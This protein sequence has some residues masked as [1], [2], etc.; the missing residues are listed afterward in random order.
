M[1]HTAPATAPADA[2]EQD[3]L[4]IGS[5]ALAVRVDPL[6]ARIGS[7]VDRR[8][9]TEFLLVT[10]WA[11][12][13]WDPVPLSQGSSVEWHR[14]YPGGW[15]TLVP[16]SG[17]ERTVGGMEHPFHG[18]AS[19]RT[20]RLVDADPSSCTHEVVLRTVPLR[21]R[22]SVRIDGGTVRVTQTVTNL[23]PEAVSFTWTEHPALGPAVVGPR[24][25]VT[26]CGED[27]GVQFP[28]D[29]GG[30]G[31]FRSI[32]VAGAGDA[33]VTDPDTGAFARLT[34]DVALLPHLHVWQEHHATDGFPW[35]RTVNTIALEPA[36]R[37]YW[38]E[39]DRLGPVV[40]DGG[41]RVTGE[42]A[43]EVGFVTAV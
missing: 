1:T 27:V 25:R 18:E 22:R 39:D 29:E 38:P 12:E 43:L 15:H 10:P 21:V 8:T 9:S 7:I 11:D 36:S 14:R 24:S 17:D 42:F 30:V 19:W 23:S 4:T 3:L 5:D 40:V 35:W 37:P 6:G 33:E 2:P 31:G 26:V 32:H 13:V 28:R 16:H 41:G 34:W 20:W